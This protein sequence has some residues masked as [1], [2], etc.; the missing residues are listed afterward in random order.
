MRF[1]PLLTLPLLACSPTNT[2]PEEQ[3]LDAVDRTSA[4][5]SADVPA[6][7][8]GTGSLDGSDPCGNRCGALGWVCMERRMGEFGCEPIPDGGSCP[9]GWFVCFGR[10]WN[11]IRL[12]CG[13]CGNACSPGQDCV[14]ADGGF[15]CQ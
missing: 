8:A 14:A 11:D 13:A 10:C 5:N 1:W 7:D 6:A 2:T 15:V 3:A 4:E 9:M 12:H